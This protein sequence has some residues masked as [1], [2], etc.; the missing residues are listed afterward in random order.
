MQDAFKEEQIK[1]YGLLTYTQFIARHLED[2]LVQIEGEIE[3]LLEE[4]TEHEEDITYAD[5]QTE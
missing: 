4:V 5:F 3:V 2:F 1:K